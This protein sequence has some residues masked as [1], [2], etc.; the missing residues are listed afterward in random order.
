MNGR[1]KKKPS[2]L[3]AIS[4]TRGERI[5]G[6]ASTSVNLED[7]GIASPRR[8]RAIRAPK[9]LPLLVRGWGGVLSANLGGQI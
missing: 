8:K 9:S 5:R 6:T 3:P 1:E 2:G 7:F 4:P